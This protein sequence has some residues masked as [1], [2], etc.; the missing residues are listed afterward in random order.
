MENTVTVNYS[1]TGASTGV[2]AQGMREMQKRAYEE[3]E[4]QY[5]LLKAPPASGKSRAL[6]FI[7]LYKLRYQ[8]IRKAIVA[9]PETSIGSSFFAT[10]LTENGFFADWEPDEQYNLCTPGS[11]E[12]KVRRFKDFMESDSRILICTHATLRFTFKEVPSESFNGCLLAIDE[13]HHVSADKESNRLGDLVHDLITKSD[14]H[15]VAMTGSYFRGDNVPVL[16]PEDEARFKSVVY[17]YYDQLNGYTY[18]KSLG[19]GHHFYQGQYI[20]GLAEILD[21]DKK[22]IIHI[23]HVNSAESTG[24]KEQEVGQIL[25]LIGDVVS[26]QDGILHVKRRKD[27]KILKIADLVNDDPAYRARVEAYLNTVRNPEDLDMVI[28]LNKAQEGYDW[29]MCEHA[30]TIGYRGSLTQIIQII[31]RATRDYPGK[32]HTQFTN[33]LAMPKAADDE[34]TLSVNNMLKAIT[35]SLLMEQVLA[36]DFKFLNRPARNPK[37]IQIKGLKEPSTPKVKEIVEKDLTELTAQIMQ[38]EDVRKAIASSQVDPLM[39]NRVLIPRVIATRYPGLTTEEI[40]E[41]RQ[42]VVVNNAMKQATFLDGGNGGTPTGSDAPSGNGGGGAPTG[43]GENKGESSPASS[44]FVD[45]NGRWILV[46]D[47]S[48]N[49]IDAINPFQ[50]AFEVI[51]KRLTAPV[52]RLIRDAI[53]TTRVNMTPE[54]ALKFWHNIKAFKAEHGREPQKNP[55]DPNEQLLYEALLTLLKYKREQAHA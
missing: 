17:S 24:D 31:G 27:G 46:D 51:S 21:T 40:E 14:A 50:Q 45:I 29:P 30:L 4:Q 13:F 20:S 12:G 6:M 1:G 25:D 11:D 52:F 2:D 38:D 7:A 28:A 22:T 53:E 34:V 55:N 9:V 37:E 16:M 26:T 36:P 42:H 35:A 41:V 8:N 43:T 5:I 48:I 39:T 44:K 23:P 32:V 33:L 18:L 3:R 54:E 19:I 49:L 10:K 15:I 47:L